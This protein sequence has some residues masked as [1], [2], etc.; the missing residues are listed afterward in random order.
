MDEAFGKM[1]QRQGLDAAIAYAATRGVDIKH[2]F[3]ALSKAPS[4]LLTPCTVVLL[5]TYFLGSFKETF[6][7]DAEQSGAVSDAS[8]SV[9]AE[10]SSVSI[11]VQSS[12]GASMFYVPLTF[13]ALQI[14]VYN[15]FRLLGPA[16]CGEQCR[17]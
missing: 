8:T 9:V 12:A 17:V 6:G 5:R 16:Q 1:R 11:S 3:D 10:L 14:A 2:Y 15:G 4:K 7:T 13:P